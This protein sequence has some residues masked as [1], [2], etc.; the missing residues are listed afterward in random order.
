MCGLLSHRIMQEAWEYTVQINLRILYRLVRNL[1]QK[2]YKSILRH[3]D[4]LVVSNSICV[5][6]FL[7]PAGIHWMCM[8]LKSRMS[9][10][11]LP[12]LL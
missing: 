7:L 2:L 6:G 3:H 1:N 9:N 11:A 8:F 5:N 10:F 12:N 4:F